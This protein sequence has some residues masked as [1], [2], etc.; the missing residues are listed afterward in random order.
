MLLACGQALRRAAQAGFGRRPDHHAG[1]NGGDVCE[2]AGE[3]QDHRDGNERLNDRHEVGEE[4]R[5]GVLQVDPEVKLWLEPAS[6]PAGLA[7][8]LAMSMPM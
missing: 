1:G 3:P 5:P 4:Y 2:L 7:L 6:Q 8:G